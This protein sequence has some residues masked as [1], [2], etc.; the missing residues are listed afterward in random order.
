MEAVDLTLLI[1]LGAGLACGFLNTAASSGSAVSLPILILMG[2]DPIS[3]N[4]TN[5]IPVLIGAVTATMSFHAKKAL[6]WGMALKL[7]VPTTLGGLLGALLAEQMPARDLGLVI[8]AAVLVAF[9]LIF[10]KLKR[11]IETASSE[12]VQVRPREVFVLFAVGIWLGFV[13][14]DGATYLLLALTLGVGLSL[15]HANAVKCALIVPAT[16]VAMVV[17]VSRG[18]IDWTIGAVMGVGSVAGGVL[19]AKVATA[20]AAKCYVFAL[21]V[22]VISAELIQLA[23]H[24]L[25]ETH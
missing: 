20:P 12:T 10:T 9:A 22:I 23:W 21:L 25:F 14:L 24:F 2:L 3:A 5:R 1:A 18:D 19:G 11:V 7:S 17:F 4:A 15:V 6:P 13:V 8:T 16:L